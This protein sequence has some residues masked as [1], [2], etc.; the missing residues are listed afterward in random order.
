MHDLTMRTGRLT[1]NAADPCLV[2]VAYVDQEEAVVGLVET[3]AEVPDVS[4]LRVGSHGVTVDEDENVQ[5]DLLV[6][7]TVRFLQDLEELTSRGSPARRPEG[8]EPG[9]KGGRDPIDDAHD[10]LGSGELLVDVKKIYGC[11]IS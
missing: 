4:L 1:F 6:V 5:S 3:S 10:V 11:G 9:R 2:I 8:D 7:Q